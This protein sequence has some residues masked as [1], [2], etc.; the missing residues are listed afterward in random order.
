MRYKI[1]LIVIILFSTISCNK[2]NKAEKI[3]D[4]L[5][6]VTFNDDRITNSIG[7]T[8]IPKAKKDLSNWKEY[9]NV[10]DFISKYYNISKMDALL[11]AKE[12]SDLVKAMKDTIRV[13]KLTELSIIARFNVLHNESLRL[14][15][16]AKIPSI[17]DN[18]VR[19]EVENIL[20][21]YSAVNS[22]IN[23]I[24]KAED[25]Q[26]LLDIDT[27]TPLKETFGL[28]QVKQ[29]NLKRTSSKK[30]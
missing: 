11:Y 21:I 14:A 28:K 10:D 25:L 20:E 4:S 9:Q 29:S 23:T 3:T 17:T 22:K 13:D 12:L 5:D 27:E 30:Q 1:A 2:S 15:D 19:E 7:E 24:Y 6:T 16:M 26:N 18:E 8:L